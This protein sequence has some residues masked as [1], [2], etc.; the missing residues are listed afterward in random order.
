[1]VKSNYH[2]AEN[3]QSIK[4]HSGITEDIEELESTAIILNFADHGFQFS[5]YGTRKCSTQ[6]LRV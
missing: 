1:M 3:N 2:S 4:R 5:L 6:T